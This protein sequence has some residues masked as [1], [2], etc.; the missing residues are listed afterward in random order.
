MALSAGMGALG[1]FAAAIDQENYQELAESADSEEFA[2]MME[3]EAKSAAIE[4]EKAKE[5]T[6]ADL[7]A[8]AMALLMGLDPGV[9]PFL[10]LGRFVSGSPNVLIGGFPMPGWEMILR[11]LG[12]LL[13]RLPRRLRL[14]K[15]EGGCRSQGHCV[16]VGH[17]VDA[18]TG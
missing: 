5:Q 10:C 3:A 6:I 2:A 1:Y 9:P 14:K 18:A 4:A 7:A 15:P 11:G 13:R 17:P 16:S 12:K 8:M